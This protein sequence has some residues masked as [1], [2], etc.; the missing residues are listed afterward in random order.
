MSSD[1]RTVVHVPTPNNLEESKKSNEGR[2]HAHPV[3]VNA[4]LMWVSSRK[5]VL[6]DITRGS[7][8]R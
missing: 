6:D 2:E 8:E 7:Y 5:A 1:Q 4:V 3:G